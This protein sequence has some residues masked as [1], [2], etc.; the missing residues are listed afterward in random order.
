MENNIN[1]YGTSYVEWS[2]I[3]AGAVLAA[4]FSLVIVQFGSAIGLADINSLRDPEIVVTPARVIGTGFFI[5]II[6]VLASMI[7]GYT[8]G[9][10]RAP[11]AGSS[12][13][14]SEIRDGMH[15]V[16]TWATGMIAVAVTVAVVSLI[17]GLTAE[18]TAT[19]DVVKSA[20]LI[21]REHNIAIMM[22]FA[23]G[24]TSLV[25]AVAAWA[26]AVSA[27][28]HRDRQVDYGRH[29]TFLVRR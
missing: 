27:G 12:A 7:G 26:A 5:L 21:N 4:A 20:D 8:A 17:T 22:A 24:A 19:T 14:E 18:P 2:A 29:L 16:L 10:M 25:S 6:Q 15:G 11:V 3:I 28:D 9:R 1:P 23:A 13:H